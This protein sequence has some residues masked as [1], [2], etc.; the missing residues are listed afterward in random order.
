[1]PYKIIIKG[2]NILNASEY[3]NL[4]FSTFSLNNF[5][6]GEN[7]KLKIYLSDQ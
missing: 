1:M 3:T 6:S 2:E 4:T 5:R 7:K